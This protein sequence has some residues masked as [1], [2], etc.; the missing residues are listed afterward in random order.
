MCIY[1]DLLRDDTIPVDV[2]QRAERMLKHCDGGSVGKS[3]YVCVFE[4]VCV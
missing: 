2:R 4:Y 3:E 1:P